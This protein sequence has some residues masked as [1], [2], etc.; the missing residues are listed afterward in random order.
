MTRAALFLALVITAIVAVAGQ[1]P[2]AGQNPA[3]GG[4]V[5]LPVVPN[6]NIEVV[7]TVPVVEPAPVPLPAPAT[8]PLPAIVTPEELAKTKALI[9][10]VFNS[11]TDGLTACD[12]TKL[13]VSLGGPAGARD[14]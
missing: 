4:Q 11:S 5:T 12:R 13:V 2:V 3:V 14:P 6:P 8:P 9:E 7:P 10:T 1:D